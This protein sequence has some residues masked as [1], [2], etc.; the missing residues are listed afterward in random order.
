MA[1][2]EA[3]AATDRV[4]ETGYPSLGTTAAAA[5]AT[6]LLAAIEAQ[7]P[8]PL[9]KTQAAAVADCLAQQIRSTETLHRVPLR[10]CDLPAFRFAAIAGDDSR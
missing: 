3:S 2:D 4:G 9:S 7:R 8:T 1:V 5:L 6:H 10:N